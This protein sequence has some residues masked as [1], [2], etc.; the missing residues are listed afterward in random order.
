MDIQAANIAV[1]ERRFG[2]NNIVS[3]Y[4]NNGFDMRPLAEGSISLIYCFDAMVHFDSDVI[5]SY[6][7]DSFRVL[8]PNGR[9]FFHHS[10]YVGGHDWRENP[11]SRNFMSAELFE[12]YAMKEQLQIVR[13]KILR[14]GGIEN[15]DC[16]TLLERPG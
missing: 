4:T 10:N 6:L 9:A 13:Q 11:H 14:W 7:R 8:K 2:K 3:F 16:F 1:C 15:L 12:H 5:R